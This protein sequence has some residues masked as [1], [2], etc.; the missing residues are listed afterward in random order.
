MDANSQLSL[1]E[2]LD[3]LPDNAEKE[4]TDFVQKAFA[5]RR[6]GALTASVAPTPAAHVTEYNK[7][8]RHMM[9][10]VR[11]DFPDATPQ[12]LMRIVAKAW[13]S[14]Q[15]SVVMKPQSKSSQKASRSAYAGASAE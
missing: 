6:G 15:T 3:A 7:F 4:V 1:L 5:A 13:R 9:P 14:R 8:T 12:E 10:V 2:L 11:Q